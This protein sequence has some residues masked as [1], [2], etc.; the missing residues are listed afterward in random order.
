M[1]SHLP[2]GNPDLTAEGN[3]RLPGESGG[4]QAMSGHIMCVT[5]FISRLLS[6]SF[7]ALKYS[8][9]RLGLSAISIPSILTTRAINLSVALDLRV[10]AEGIFADC[11]R[12]FQIFKLITGKPQLLTF[13]EY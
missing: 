7:G 8:Y 6:G 2:G 9:P 4:S 3:H 13:F 5:V 11:E 12:F 10:T 1:V